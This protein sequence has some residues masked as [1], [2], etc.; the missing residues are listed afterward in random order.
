MR[1]ARVPAL[2]LEAEGNFPAFKLDCKPYYY[3]NIK[4]DDP[5]APSAFAW[6]EKHG[7]GDII[8]KTYTIVVGKGDAKLSKRIEA[9]LNKAK[10]PFEVKMAVPWNTLTAFLR[11]QIEKFKTMPPL[12]LLGGKVGSVVDM[13]V[14]KPKGEEPTR[15]GDKF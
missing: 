13:K 3:A 9:T 15:Q 5:L 7:H 4:A 1:E 10:I 6:L 8:K 12:D 14:M 11:E 2:T